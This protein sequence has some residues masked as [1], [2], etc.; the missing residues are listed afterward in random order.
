[1]NY[2]VSKGAGFSPCPMYGVVEY[3][4][5]SNVKKEIASRSVE[6][7][8]GTSV[9]TFA[10]AEVGSETQDCMNSTTSDKSPVSDLSESERSCVRHTS[11]NMRVTI[12]ESHTEGQTEKIDVR[13]P[14]ALLEEVEGKYNQE[15]YT[16]RSE[17]IRDALRNWVDLPVTRSEE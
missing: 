8:D 1:M 13:V 17:A 11:H 3:D 9:S 14:V 10:F 7:S 6:P 16:S 4:N 15:R 12:E 2:G 5:S